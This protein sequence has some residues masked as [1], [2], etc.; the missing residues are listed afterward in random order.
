MD[1]IC[2]LLSIRTRICQSGVPVSSEKTYTNIS[3]STN[4]LLDNGYTLNVQKSTNDTINLNFINTVL[5]F[6]FTF[7]ISNNS[8]TV[9]DLPIDSGTYRLIIFVTM[10]CCNL[11]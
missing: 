3:S 4:I 5:G 1:N 6:N 9:Y 2:F 10:R 11:C 8:T 7:N